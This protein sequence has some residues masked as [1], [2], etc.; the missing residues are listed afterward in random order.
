MLSHVATLEC[1]A[2]LATRHTPALPGASIL[3]AIF[4]IVY[5]S[6]IVLV[7]RDYDDFPLFSLY[8]IRTATMIHMDKDPANN[9]T[10]LLVFSTI[11]CATVPS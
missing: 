5:I 7:A 11:L 6:S 1:D 4:S 2:R 8:K 3:F 9:V 10:S